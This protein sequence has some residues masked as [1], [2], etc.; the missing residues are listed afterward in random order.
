MCLATRAEKIL[1]KFPEGTIKLI[2][3]FSVS[4]QNVLAYGFDHYKSNLLSLFN[5]VGTNL[6]GAVKWSWILPQIPI[7]HNHDESFGYLCLAGIILFFSLIIILLKNIKKIDFIKYRAVILI[8]IF[9]FIIALSNKIELADRILFEIPLN[10]YLY[11]FV[12][13]FRVPGRFLWVCYYL[14]LIYGII[15]IYKSCKGTNCTN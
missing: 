9:F 15:I 10:K 7:N 13:L 1:P 8:F 4:L 2:L 14:I 12:S 11:G 5:P 3:F 6:N